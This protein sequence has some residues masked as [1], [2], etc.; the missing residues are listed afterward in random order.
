[1][2]GIMLL[3]SVIGA[4]MKNNGDLEL[5]PLMHQLVSSSME[6]RLIEQWLE[7]LWS[8]MTTFRSVVLCRFWIVGMSLLF[9]LRFFETMENSLSLLSLSDEIFSAQVRPQVWGVQPINLIGGVVLES[10]Q[11]DMFLV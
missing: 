7:V 8:W 2:I 1:M 9:C 6:N 11:W 5:I 10:Y 4:R 3:H